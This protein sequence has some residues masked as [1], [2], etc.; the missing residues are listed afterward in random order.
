MV[1]LSVVIFTLYIA[2]SHSMRRGSDFSYL[3]TGK[4]LIHNI[5]LQI[6]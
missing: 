6:E 5:H 3:F 1:L 4:Y 2:R